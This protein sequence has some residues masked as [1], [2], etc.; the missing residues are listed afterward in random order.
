MICKLPS[1]AL[2]SWPGAFHPAVHYTA[3]SWNSGALRFS[4][5]R[6]QPEPGR[7]QVPGLY[8]IHTC[9]AGTRASSRNLTGAVLLAARFAWEHARPEIR[10]LITRC[11]VAPPPVPLFIPPSPLGLVA[12]SHARKWSR[13]SD[14]MRIHLELKDSVQQPFT[15]TFSASLRNYVFA[16]GTLH[17]GCLFKFLKKYFGN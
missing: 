12:L 14:L 4:R 7:S 3:A 13:I 11:L 16:S 15:T 2:S 17:L 6:G 1:S 8:L 9:V 5:Q 10:Y